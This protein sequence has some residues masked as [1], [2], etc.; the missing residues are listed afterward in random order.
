MNIFALKAIVL[1]V[2]S[3]PDEDVN[4]VYKMFEE[5]NYSYEDGFSVLS[6]GFDALNLKLDRIRSLLEEN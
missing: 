6:S 4:E 3:E 1:D 5:D 2:I